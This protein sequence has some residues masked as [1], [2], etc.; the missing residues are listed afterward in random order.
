MR[1]VQIIFENVPGKPIF[2]QQIVSNLSN[3]NLILKHDL[4]LNNHWPMWHLKINVPIS[5]LCIIF[6]SSNCILNS[7]KYSALLYLR[8]FRKGWIRNQI[9]FNKNLIIGF[10]FCFQLQDYIKLSHIRQDA[11]RDLIPFAQFKKRKK[12]KWTSGTF[13]KVTDCSSSPSWMFF[14]FFKLYL[15]KSHQIAQSIRNGHLLTINHLTFGVHRNGI[16]DKVFKNGPS[17]ICGRRPLR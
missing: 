7:K 4:I 10:E 9:F 13:S 1:Q 14:T 6:C 12:H 2:P 15:K 16:W 17:K 5:Y 3:Q 8:I 11:L